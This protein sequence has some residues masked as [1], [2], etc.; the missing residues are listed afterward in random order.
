[1]PEEV[2]KNY[3]PNYGRNLSIQLINLNKINQNNLIIGHYYGYSGD[4]PI[5][6]LGGRMTTYHI[7][8]YDGQINNGIPIM[9]VL[10]SLF[11][12]SN[13]NGER[14]VYWTHGLE[15]YS[16]C[17]LQNP[18]FY[19][20]S[21][22][23]I[24]DMILEDQTISDDMKNQLLIGLNRIIHTGQHG[25]N[26]VQSRSQSR[27]QSRAQSPELSHV[28]SRAQSREQSPVTTSEQLLTCSICMTN[29]L[30]RVL[31][32]GH[33]L[34]NVCSDNPGYNACHMCRVPITYRQRDIRP[35]FLS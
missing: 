19:Q 10:F 28:L 1:M 29:V 24:R 18:T 11:Q 3:Q 26:L 35:L 27:A 13:I 16:I 14:V 12:S 9:H 23:T 15:Y 6:I 21:Y 34:C 22:T 32:C 7:V 4:G 30:N 33:T 2:F 25:L 20:L 31:L 8:R 17:N 5:R